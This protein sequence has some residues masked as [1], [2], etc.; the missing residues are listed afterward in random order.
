MISSPASCNYA[1]LFA[2]FWD[3]PNNTEIF[4]QD[5]CRRDGEITSG[6]IENWS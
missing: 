3:R 1:N 4:K 5:S 6:P 2:R